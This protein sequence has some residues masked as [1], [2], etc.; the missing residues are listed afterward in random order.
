MG[1]TKAE[2]TDFLNKCD[3]LRAS[4]FIMATTRIKDILKSIAGSEALYGMF[5][6]ITAGFDYVAAKRKYFI[7]GG[8]RFYGRSRLI[9]PENAA[10]RLAFTF[11]L[12]VEFD[13]G[14]INFNEFLRRYFAVDGSYFSS[15]HDFCDKV[16][17]SME[18]IIREVFAAELAQDDATASAAEAQ[19]VEAAQLYAQ[20]GAAGMAGINGMT[21]TVGAAGTDKIS[22]VGI[23]I[24]G[25]KNYIA[26]LQMSKAEK[27]DGFAML[28]AL[29]SAVRGGNAEAADAILR[30]Y[31]YYLA[32]HKNFSKL[33]ER[34]NAAM[35]D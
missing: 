23:L 3:Q 24:N 10:E 20:R 13:H 16:I 14:D 15:F 1:N 29:F 32:C 5:S 33:F 31:E 30:G 8:E 19:R 22:A 21:G 25:E 9:L 7:G 12:L 17:L 11:C 34:L 35:G 27:E 6:E 28:D 2:V 26:S 4:K 18:E